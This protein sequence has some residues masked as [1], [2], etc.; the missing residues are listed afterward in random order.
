MFVCVAGQPRGI[1]IDERTCTVFPPKSIA[2]RQRHVAPPMPRR[3]PKETSNEV[4]L[5]SVSPRRRCVSSR[6]L[7]PRG[8]T[9]MKRA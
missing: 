3:G 2:V 1:A 7:S 4:P 5:V 8:T 9:L 6:A